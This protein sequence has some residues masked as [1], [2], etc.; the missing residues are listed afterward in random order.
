MP[1]F[2]Y[3][4]RAHT[5]AFLGRTYTW[6]FVLADLRTPLLGA[7]FLAHHGLLVDVALQH[8]LDTETCLSCSLARGPRA[9]TICSIL[10]HHRYTS[11]LQEFPNIFHPELHQVAGATPKNGVF[12]HIETKDPPTHAKFRRLP[13]KLLQ[14]TKTMFK[15]MEKMGI[16]KKAVSLWSSPLHMVKKADNTWRPVVTTSA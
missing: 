14:E 7:D 5:I 13:P 4:T 8:L 6:P 9:P 11:L 12:H 10:P 16:C 3:G 2:T 1:T 15:E